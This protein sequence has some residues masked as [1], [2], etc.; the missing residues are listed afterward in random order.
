MFEDVVA[1]TGSEEELSD[2]C[3][4]GTGKCWTGNDTTDGDISEEEGRTRE[5]FCREEEEPVSWAVM[6][7]VITTGSSD[8]IVFDIVLMINIG[9]VI[10]CW[11]WQKED[12]II[13]ERDCILCFSF[14][15]I[16]VS[17]SSFSVWEASTSLGIY[18]VNASSCSSFQ[19]EGGSSLSSIYLTVEKLSS[20]TT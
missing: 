4:T 17:H 5:L 8:D 12:R 10:T 19:K 15:S 3:W 11:G 7:S 16:G 1:I 2:K 14:T 18:V 13:S 9:S 6:V 20:K